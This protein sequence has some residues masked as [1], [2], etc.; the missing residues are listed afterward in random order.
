MKRLLRRVSVGTA[1]AG[2]SLLLLGAIVYASG[3]RLNSTRSI[4]LGVY[5]LTSDP[6]AKGAY[7]LFCPPQAAVFDE[8]KARGYIGA[9]FCP[10][11]YGYLMKRVLAAKGDAVS[12]AEEGVRVNGELLPFSAPI[13]A[14]PAGRPLPRFAADR[15]TLSASELLLMSDVSGKSFDGRY[16]GPIDRS[17]IKGVIRPVFTW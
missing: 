8:A 16:F 3:V 11:D 13:P 12:I 15:F 6:V 9:G 17:Q 10:G 7:V 1:V 4:P 5:W 14:D 2:V